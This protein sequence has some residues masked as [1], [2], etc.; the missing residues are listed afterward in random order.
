M[1]ERTRDRIFAACGISSVVLELIGLI[2]GVIGGRTMVSISSSSTD[3]AAAAAQ[4]PAAGVWVGAYLELLS[5]GAFLAFAVWAT[6]KLGGGVLGS[7]TRAMATCFTAVSIA[8]LCVLDAFE[9][10]AGTG[11]DVQLAAALTKVNEALYVGTWFF[12]AFFLIGAGFQALTAGRRWLGWSALAIAA[13]T[14][15]GTA[16]SID[17]V[18]QLAYQLWLI[19]IIVSSVALCRVRRVRPAMPD[20]VSISS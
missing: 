18:G 2:I 14:L 17:D 11:L 7:V 5:F 9:F 10:Q 6:E 15:T 13:I 12:Y 8:S 19:W 1:Q 4:P 16:V 3:V 20:A